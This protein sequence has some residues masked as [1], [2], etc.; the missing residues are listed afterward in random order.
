MQKILLCYHFRGVLWEDPAFCSQR[1][2]I[3][4]ASGLLTPHFKSEIHLK[5]VGSLNRSWEIQ[6]FAERWPPISVRC[7]THKLY[8]QLLLIFIH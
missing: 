7:L 3:S 6:Y 1:P 2:M 5:S 8:L 4:K